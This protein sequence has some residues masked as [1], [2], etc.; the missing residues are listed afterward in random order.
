MR[1]KIGNIA[2]VVLFAVTYILFFYMLFD[3][4]TMLNIG[5]HP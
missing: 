4:F 3:L 5:E 1:K 2:F